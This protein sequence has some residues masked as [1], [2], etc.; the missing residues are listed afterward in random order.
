MYK[1]VRRRG[2]GLVVGEEQ[3]GKREA[4]SLSTLTTLSHM[5]PNGAFPSCKLASPCDV[6]AHNHSLVVC[7][8]SGATVPSCDPTST[9][10]K[11]SDSTQTNPVREQMMFL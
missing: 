11:H 6:I 3:L 5:C 4:H 7:S 9:A 8:A 10:H 2:R 1:G